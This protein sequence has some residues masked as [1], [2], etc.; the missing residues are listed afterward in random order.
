MEKEVDLLLPVLAGISEAWLAD[1]NAAEKGFSL[2]FFNEAYLR[3]LPAAIIRK[4][5]KIFAFAN[6]WPGGDFQE[7]SIDLMRFL[8]EAPH[9]IMDFLFLSIM[10][11]GKEQRYRWFSFGM[12]PLA[13]LE[14]QKVASLWRNIGTFVYRHGEHFYNFQ[15]LREYKDKFD[16]VWEP[17][18]LA[19]PQAFSLP[20][21]FINLSALIGG[22]LKGIFRS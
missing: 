17:K 3:R 13:G 6:L 5:E 20:A 18:Y 12:A 8:P 22:G 11:W 9:G 16:P 15:G 7:L 19:Y 1:K 10:L 4:D 14:R 21:I 2:G